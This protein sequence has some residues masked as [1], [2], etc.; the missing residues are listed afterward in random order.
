MVSGHSPCEV[1]AVTLGVALVVEGVDGGVVGVVV[2]PV[3]GSEV[4]TASPRPAA[5]ITPIASSTA[6]PNAAALTCIFR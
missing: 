6:A 4:V 3:G 2:S 1:L 5:V